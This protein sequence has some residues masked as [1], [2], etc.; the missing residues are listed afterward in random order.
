M[1]ESLTQT[2]GWLCGHIRFEAREPA[3][4][5]DTCSCTTC[6]RHTGSITAAWLEFALKDAIWT[7]AGSA[8]AKYK[9]SKWSNRAFC[10]KGG[11]SIG[12]IDQKPVIVF[13]LGTFDKPKAKAFAPQYHS[14]VTSRPEWWH[15]EIKDQARPGSDQPLIIANPR[16]A[17][18]AIKPPAN[19]SSTGRASAFI[20]T[21][22]AAPSSEAVA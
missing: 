6:Q 3:L 8:P 1:A 13:P 15:F 10:P 9:P 5:P 20:I 14:Y 7:G 21:N 4:K 11:S 2:G 12:A 22:T 18:A 19:A 16:R 17:N